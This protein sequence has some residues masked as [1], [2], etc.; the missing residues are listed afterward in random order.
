MSKKETFDLET[1]RAGACDVYPYHSR[2]LCNIEPVPI[3]GFRK[4]N[5]GGWAVDE[6]WRVYYDPAFLEEYEL[7]ACVACLI[8]EHGHPTLDHFG[9]F[10]ALPVRKDGTMWTAEEWNKAADREM[11]GSDPFLLKHLPKWACF[12]E[13]IGK[14]AGLL[15]EEYLVREEGGGGKKGKPKCGQCGSEDVDISA[16]P[17]AAQGEMTCNDCG[18]KE[19]VEVKWDC[20]GGA[21]GEQRPWELGPPTAKNPGVARGQGEIL[22][23]LIARDIQEH[24]KTQG[25]VPGNWKSWAEAVL[26]PPKTPWQQVFGRFL[27]QCS[28][29]TAGAYDF[30][31]QR[32]NRRQ[33]AYGDVILPACYQPKLE[34]GVVLDT[35]G[36][37]SS[38]DLEYACSEINGILRAAQSS[39]NVVCCDSEAHAAQKITR[40]QNIQI[41]GRGGTDMTVG[42][43][44]AAKGSP[45]PHVLVCLTD[46]FT[47]WPQRGD[48][49]Q[50]IIGGIIYGNRYG[51]PAD[52][53]SWIHTVEIEKEGE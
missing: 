27:R 45:A 4:Q 13:Q 43:L 16:V 10:K 51:K 49:Q 29:M 24:A 14:K 18:H 17:G 31:F 38:S 25:N 8:H 2:G 46:G 3:E 48:I 9:R 37:M 50:P 40:A 32:R 47:D 22:R 30:T 12:P 1:V 33:S 52:P 39:V 20:G 36:S 41:L 53:P 44:A 11:N 23:E 7:A 19:P 34:V 42:L 6:F 26:E 15:A 35:S 5:P 28:E 21:G